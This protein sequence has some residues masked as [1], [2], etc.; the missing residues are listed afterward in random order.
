MAGSTGQRDTPEPGGP[1]APGDEGARSLLGEALATTVRLGRPLYGAA[2][3]VTALAACGVAAI[4]VLGFS[5]AW[6]AFVLLRE[7]V[8]SN[9]D[10]EVPPF[11]A[12]GDIDV[13]FTLTGILV[14]LLLLLLLAVVLTLLYAAHAAAVRDAPSGSGAPPAGGLWRRAR[15]HLPRVLGTQL[16]TGLCVVVAALVAFSLFDSL[17]RDLIPGVERPRSPFTG[18]GA[19]DWAVG[20]GL[21]LAAGCVGPYAM[22]RLSLAPSAVVFEDVGVWRAV[23]RSWT[24]T[25]GAQAG[26]AGLWLL[27]AAAVA[28]AFTLLLLAASPLALPAEEAMMRFSDGNIFVTAT[29]V[30][31]TPAAVALVLLP[32]AV[33]P[34]VG[35]ALPVLYTRLRAREEGGA[36]RRDPAAAA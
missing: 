19:A 36:L 29:L 31:Y 5:L 35:V 1:A 12:T 2:L 30:H 16:L 27:T 6:D 17:A 13:T 10:Q 33:M 21:P 14:V 25:R 8:R 28:V 26:A 7:R 22:V 4:A 3:A 11:S 20:L 32:V 18:F 34:P 24:L 23:R 15:P 9:L